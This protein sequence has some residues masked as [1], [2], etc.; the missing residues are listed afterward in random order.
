MEQIGIL[1]DVIEDCRS[2]Y[3]N[4]NTLEQVE[5]TVTTLP[6]PQQPLPGRLGSPLM[7][8]LAVGRRAYDGHAERTASPGNCPQT[9]LETAAKACAFPSDVLGRTDHV[10]SL[11]S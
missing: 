9:K 11:V 8:L 5:R 7:C 1:I 2:R 10:V 4:S 6:G 3:Q